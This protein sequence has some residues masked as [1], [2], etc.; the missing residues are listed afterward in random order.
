[1]QFNV[2]KNFY[3]RCVF[4]SLDSNR[5]EAIRKVLEHANFF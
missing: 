2:K 4:L 1:M 3:L 5:Q